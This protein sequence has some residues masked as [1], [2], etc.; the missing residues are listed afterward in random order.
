VRLKARKLDIRCMRVFSPRTS[1]EFLDFCASDSQDRILQGPDK[2]MQTVVSPLGHTGIGSKAAERTPKQVS[3]YP[4]ESCGFID[5]RVDTSPHFVSAEVSLVPGAQSLLTTPCTNR[6]FSAGNI[7]VAMGSKPDVENVGSLDDTQGP[8]Y[9]TQGKEYQYSYH[10]DGSE[11]VP[12]TVP[13]YGDGKYFVL[14]NF[15]FCSL[16]PFVLH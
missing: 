13:R 2:H 11:V 10:R 5:T 15:R 6:I 9:Q 7:S 12:R 3:S 14:R 8:E 1:P 16:F 4:F